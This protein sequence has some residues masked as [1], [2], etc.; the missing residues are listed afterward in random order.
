M[1]GLLS[2]REIVFRRLGLESQL[3]THH[4][5]VASLQEFQKPLCLSPSPI[6]FPGYDQNFLLKNG[7]PRW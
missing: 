5:M 1:A 3:V 4:T 6:P 7:L 2:P